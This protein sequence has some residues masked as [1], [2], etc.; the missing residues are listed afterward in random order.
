MSGFA[1]PNELSALIQ[2]VPFIIGTSRGLTAVA[3]PVGIQKF[4][5]R[6]VSG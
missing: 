4:P 6:E 3:N 5:R 2:A 1:E